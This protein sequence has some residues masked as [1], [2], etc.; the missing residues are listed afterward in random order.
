V[1]DL[2][3]LAADGTP[4]GAYLSTPPVGSGPWPGVVVI[5]DAFGLSDVTRDHADRLAAAGYLAVAPDLY[6]R[7]GMLRCVKATFA[8]LAAGEGQAFVDVEATRTWL[9]ARE[10]STGRSGIIGFCMGGGFALLGAS[11]GFD[12]SSVNYGALPAN[13]DRELEGACPIV[14]SYGHRD[15][16]LKGAAATLDDALEAKGI[17][18]DV[19]EYSDAGHSFLD[20]FNTG[21]LTVLMRVGGFAYHQPSAEVAWRRILGFFAEHLSPGQS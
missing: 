2:T 8:N 9:A 14:G 11:R 17:A 7:G 21:P 19:K 18:H 4:L 10:D 12:V 5:H 20:R 1:P 16:T 13:L 15:R 6:S 3:L